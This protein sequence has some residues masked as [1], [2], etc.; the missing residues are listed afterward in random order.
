M[1]Q[2]SYTTRNEFMPYAREAESYRRRLFL[3]VLRENLDGVFTE[4]VAQTTPDCRGCDGV[5]IAWS[6]FKYTQQY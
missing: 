1:S 5:S 2:L 3:L 6:V 4:H